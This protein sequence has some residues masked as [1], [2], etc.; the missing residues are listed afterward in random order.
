MD[1]INYYRCSTKEQEDSGLG[2]LS[3]KMICQNF[4]KQGCNH[5]LDEYLE[6]ES[7]KRDDRPELKKAISKSKETGATILVSKLDRLSRSVHF[8]SELMESGVKFICADNPQMNELTC[9]IMISLAQWERKRIS[10]RTRE[11]LQAKKKREPD[12]K[13]GT[14]NFTDSGR[15]KAYATM[16]RNSI[17]NESVRK[18]YHFICLLKDQGLTYSEIASRLNSEHYSTRNAKLFTT[19]SVFNT[20]NKFRNSPE[21]KTVV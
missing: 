12:W 2:L 6:V 20:F 14:N 18:A 5:L 4:I 13:P 10:E 11:A 1:F 17:M 9:H 3:Q 7:G 15:E 16:Y 8:V 21:H 19:M